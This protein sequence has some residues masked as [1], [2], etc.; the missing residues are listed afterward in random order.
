MGGYAMGDFDDS[1][2]EEVAKAGQQDTGKAASEAKPQEEGAHKSE[3][4]NA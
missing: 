4:G 3:G 2:D 1:D